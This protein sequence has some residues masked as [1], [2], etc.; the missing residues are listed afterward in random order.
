VTVVPFVSPRSTDAA[1][2][3]DRAYFQRNPDETVYRRDALP[4]EAPFPA[5]PGHRVQVVVRR[6]EHGARLRAFEV[7]AA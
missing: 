3:A 5:P 1:C 2:D 7:V 6:L 4:H